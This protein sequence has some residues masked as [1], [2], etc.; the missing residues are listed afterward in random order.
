MTAKEKK[1]LE[2]AQAYKD[3]KEAF[4]K[5]YPTKE[6][7]YKKLSEDVKALEEGRLE[8]YSA[9]EFERNMDDFLKELEKNNI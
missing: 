6:S 1:A 5:E 4:L 2:E 3:Y 7:Y 8:T 9:E